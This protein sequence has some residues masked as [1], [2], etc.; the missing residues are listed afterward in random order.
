MFL[1][2]CDKHFNLPLACFGLILT[3]SPTLLSLYFP[4]TMPPSFPR[5]ARAKSKT[6][7][8]ILTN[9]S[10]F[11]SVAKSESISELKSICKCSVYYLY[12]SRV[13]HYSG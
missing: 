12:N 3:R 8:G 4:L 7:P 1:I 6:E 11:N 2:S 13:T 10:S 5:S 9:I